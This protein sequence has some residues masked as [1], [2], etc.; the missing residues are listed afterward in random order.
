MINK[1]SNQDRDEHP[2]KGKHKLPGDPHAPRPS[3]G[4]EEAQGGAGGPRGVLGRESQRK[5]RTTT[6]ELLLW[7]RGNESD[8]YL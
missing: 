2:E 5:S 1:K 3:R 8:W 6:K 4:P 7:H